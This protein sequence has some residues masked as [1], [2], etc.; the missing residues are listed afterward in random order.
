MDVFAVQE[1]SADR[2]AEMGAAGP[3]RRIVRP[4][5][6]KPGGF[7]VQAIQG[8]AKIRNFRPDIIILEGDFHG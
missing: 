5:M 2:E 4:G 8:S 6:L 1:L 3:D 7:I